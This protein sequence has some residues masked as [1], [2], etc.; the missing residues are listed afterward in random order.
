MN[1]GTALTRL[2]PCLV[3]AAVVATHLRIQTL[4]KLRLVCFNRA[5]NADQADA[6]ASVATL[7]S[8][9]CGAAVVDHFSSCHSPG[10][11]MQLQQSDSVSGARGP[12]WRR[13]SKISPW[14]RQH[15]RWRRLPERRSTVEREILGGEVHTGCVQ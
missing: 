15:H 2:A 1:H 11:T 10:Y 13:C 12:R 8:D 4:A 14:R 9:E 3:R 7:A 5:I 6:V